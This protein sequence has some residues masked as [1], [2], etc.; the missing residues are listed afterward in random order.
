MNS[1]RTEDWQWQ[2]Y[3]RVAYTCSLISQ[4]VTR[5]KLRGAAPTENE[6][7]HQFDVEMSSSLRLSGVYHRILAVAPLHGPATTS[8]VHQLVATTDG[9]EGFKTQSVAMLTRRATAMQKNWLWSPR[10]VVSWMWY[11]SRSRKKNWIGL[12]CYPRFL[13]SASLLCGLLLCIPSIMYGCIPFL[14]H[15]VPCLWV[16]CHEMCSRSME[17]GH[18]AACRHANPLRWLSHNVNAVQ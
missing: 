17:N 6:T 5:S 2:S 18:E 9:T 16:K 12:E 13:H 15:F 4:T 14:V 10:V 7:F 11:R 8:E 1:T 3:L